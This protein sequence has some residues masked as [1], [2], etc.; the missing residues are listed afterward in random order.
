MVNSAFR[1]ESV[2]EYIANH[3]S[4]INWVSLPIHEVLHGDLRLEASVYA[5][6]V[7]KAKLTVMNNKFGVIYKSPCKRNTLLLAARKFIRH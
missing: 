1:I 7:E 4:R 2:D 5:T 3:Q 6:E